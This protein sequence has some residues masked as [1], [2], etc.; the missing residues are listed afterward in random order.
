[1]VHSSLCILCPYLGPKNNNLGYGDLNLA[2]SEAIQILSQTSP[3]QVCLLDK[4]GKCG[5]CENDDPS[6]KQIKSS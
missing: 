2:T 6:C 3:Y 5:T 4:I 1:M